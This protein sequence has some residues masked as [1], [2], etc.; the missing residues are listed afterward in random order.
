MFKLKCK[1]VGFDCKFV[2]KTKTLDEII[3]KTSEHT[4]SDHG[5]KPEEMDEKMIDKMLSTVQKSYF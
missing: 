3:Q 2:A 1:N 4:M 5:I